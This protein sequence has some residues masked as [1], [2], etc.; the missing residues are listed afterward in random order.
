MFLETTFTPQ[1]HYEIQLNDTALYLMWQSLPHGSLFCWGQ[2]LANLLTI[3]GNS[4]W[5][6]TIMF[7]CIT[8]RLE[9]GERGGNRTHI[10]AVLQTAPY[11]S[12][13]NS[14]GRSIPSWTGFLGF[15][16]PGTT[17]YTMLLLK[18]YSHPD[19]NGEWRFRRPYVFPVSI[20]EHWKVEVDIIGPSPLASLG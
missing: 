3:I 8:K 2:S 9:I 19:S 7:G 12:I 4:G 14:P 5:I 1:S 13:G 15:G 17:A 11:A 20:W 10:D 18:W 16:V 6:R